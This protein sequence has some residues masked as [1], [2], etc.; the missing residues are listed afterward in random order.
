MW[1]KR[2]GLS[3]F[4]VTIV[5]VFLVQQMYGQ[6]I[7]MR[8]QLVLNKADGNEGLLVLGSGET[9]SKKGVA[10]KFEAY[11]NSNITFAGYKY[12]ANNIDSIKSGDK[13]LLFVRDIDVLN[14]SGQIL[15]YID[16]KVKGAWKSIPVESITH[17]DNK[18]R[19]ISKNDIKL[20][21][22]Q[23]IK[24]LDYSI[25]DGYLFEVAK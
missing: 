14:N 2:F 13:I 1:L 24:Q 20:V 15:G 9:I 11:H 21:G 18:I 7:M 5:T 10:L 25:V 16:A 12:L 8:S 22:G 23:A 19:I 17:Y 4:A 3:V 6:K